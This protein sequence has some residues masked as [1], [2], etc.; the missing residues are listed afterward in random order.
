MVLVTMAALSRTLV[1]EDSLG[2]AVGV[3]ETREAVEALLDRVEG[4]PR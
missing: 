4:P 2:M 3:R 1:M